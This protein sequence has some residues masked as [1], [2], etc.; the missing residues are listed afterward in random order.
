MVLG[1]R[2][3]RVVEESE[4]VESLVE[5]ISEG[6]S[7]SSADHIERSSPF[8]TPNQYGFLGHNQTSRRKAHHKS[9]HSWLLSGT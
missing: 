2:E 9:P 6:F 3:V 8:L 5:A 7:R 4:R 1:L